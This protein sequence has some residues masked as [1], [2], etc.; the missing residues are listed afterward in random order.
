VLAEAE[1]DHELHVS[2]AT[3]IDLWYV[4]QTTGSVTTDELNALRDRLVSSAAVALEP[5]TVAVADAAITIP[6]AVIADPW[7]RLIVATARVLNVPLVTRDD[8]IR[9]SQLVTTIW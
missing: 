3:L 7:D 6:R 8:T 2:V 9:E 4:T 5:V 1:S